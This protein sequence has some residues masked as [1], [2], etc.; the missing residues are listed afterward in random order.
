MYKTKIK[1]TKKPWILP[2]GWSTTFIRKCRL[3]SSTRSTILVMLIHLS[4]SVSYL[5]PS[6]CLTVYHLYL[7]QPLLHIYHLSLLASYL[8]NHWNKMKSFYSSRRVHI[9]REMTFVFDATVLT[10]CFWEIQEVKYIVISSTVCL[11]VVGKG[12]FREVGLN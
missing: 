12:K 5:C 3:L 2:F 6:L 7:L 9:K 8:D 4:V 10:F 1:Q 11:K